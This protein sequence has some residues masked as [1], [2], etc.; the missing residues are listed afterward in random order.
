MGNQKDVQLLASQSFK[1]ALLAA[2]VIHWQRWTVDKSRQSTIRLPVKITLRGP[3]V[4]DCRTAEPR[5]CSRLGLNDLRSDEEDQL[6]RLGLDR[7]TFKQIAKYWN[8]SQQ[9][10]LVD[11]R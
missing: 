3:D 11:V 8:V 5:N 2:G 1:Q 7:A 6:L 9:W 10:Y 4:R